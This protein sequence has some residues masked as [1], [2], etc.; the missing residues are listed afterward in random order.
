MNGR[1]DLVPDDDVHPT[2]AGNEALAAHVTD[3]LEDRSGR[4]ARARSM[5]IGAV[6]VLGIAFL[7][8]RPRRSGTSS[9]KRR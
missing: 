1:T 5:A 4:A 7:L 3:A 8:L 2:A 9:R 6:V